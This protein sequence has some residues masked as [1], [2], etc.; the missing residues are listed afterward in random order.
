M[1]T[2]QNFDNV[3]GYGIQATGQ[4]LTPQEKEAR[5][6]IARQQAIHNKQVLQQ[7]VEQARQGV[8]QAKAIYQGQGQLPSQSEVVDTLGNVE[9]RL[10]RTAARVPGQG[11]QVVED[12]RDVVSATRN[13]MIEKQGVGTAAATL[14]KESALA[15][16]ESSSILSDKSAQ[17]RSSAPRASDWLSLDEDDKELARSAADRTLNVLKTLATSAE[18]RQIV[19]E[20]GELMRELFYVAGDRIGDTVS[21]QGEQKLN[22]LEQT[23]VSVS[24]LQAKVPEKLQQLKQSA[25]ASKESM[26]Q[27]AQGAKE[28]L[29]SQAQTAADA[30]SNQAARAAEAYGQT[31]GTKSDKLEASKQQVKQDLGTSSSYGSSSY[32]AYGM[33][34]TATDFTGSGIYGSSYG[35]TGFGTPGISTATGQTGFINSM[36]QERL[37][38]INTLLQSIL[39]QL[40]NNPEMRAA[41]GDFKYLL[42]TYKERAS[43]LSDR[44]ISTAQSQA[45]DTQSSLQSNMQQSSHAQKAV[46]AANDL[47]SRLSPGDTLERLKQEFSGLANM[48]ANE[49]A[50]YDW[51]D[52]AD[53]YATELTDH[54]EMLTQAHRDEFNARWQTLWNKGYETVDK[55][56]AEFRARMNN[57][58]N[59]LMQFVD[60]LKQDQS[61]SNFNDALTR[62]SNDLIIRDSQGR[63][64]FNTQAVNEIRQTLAPMLVEQFSMMPLPP[65]D[66]SDDTYDLHIDDMVL[67]MTE[68]PPSAIQAYLQNFFS[69]DMAKAQALRTNGRLTVYMRNIQIE[70]KKFR[71]RFQ[72]KSFPK[73]SD[74]G[75]ATFYTKDKGISMALGFRQYDTAPFISHARAKCVVDN[76]KIQFHSDTDHKTLFNFFTSVFKGR[77][78]KAIEKA[79]EEQLVKSGNLLADR[80]NANIDLWAAKSSSAIAAISDKVTQALPAGSG[81]STSSFDSRTSYSAAPSSYS[82]TPTV[83]GVSS[84]VPASSGYVSSS[85]ALPSSGAYSSSGY[86][87]PSSSLSSYGTGVSGSGAGVGTRTGLASGSGSGFGSNNRDER[88]VHR[89]FDPVAPVVSGVIGVMPAASLS[90][91]PISSAP[92]SSYTSAPASSYTSTPHSSSASSLKDSVGARKSG[93]DPRDRDIRDPTVSAQ[94]LAEGS[95]VHHIGS[96]NL[97]DYHKEDLPY[98]SNLSDVRDESA[99]RR[100]MKNADKQFS[101]QFAKDTKD[102]SRDYTHHFNKETDKDIRR[103]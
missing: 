71:F 30:V 96:D 53:Q 12:M 50:I 83:V 60:E 36:S 27:Q 8:Q 77:I 37:N 91:A 43:E 56:G 47:V 65:I 40:S 49:P 80:L 2:N 78:E 26:A 63:A 59:L 17:L 33:P 11:G 32:G 75:H 62:L 16:Q 21:V 55:L 52:L 51:L 14:A 45:Y 101:A 22:E 34:S 4:H 5:E 1:S 23:D 41:W 15:A 87:Q 9:Q 25:Q 38:R 48:V 6:D 68:L 28:S 13:L 95:R 94:Q 66:Y 85:S 7:G 19:R 76:L 86:A 82:S 39:T 54:P 73:I 18:G 42:R 24:N 57:I 90:A 20:F 103:M 46:E 35:T 81:A 74:E 10:D 72:R 44:M 84:G 79:V 98:R 58:S 99:E 88:G 97:N 89:A 69:L 29:K 31:P 102:L 92:A 64:H 3:R 93:S 70:A 100:G 61:L 67:N